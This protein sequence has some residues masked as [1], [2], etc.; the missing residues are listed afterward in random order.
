MKAHCECIEEAKHE[1][2]GQTKPTGLF[3]LPGVDPSNAEQTEETHGDAQVVD[4]CPSTGG[5]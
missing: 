1:I 2:A 5:D 4:D 3:Q